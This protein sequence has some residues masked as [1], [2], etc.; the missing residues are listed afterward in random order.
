MGTLFY[1][2]WELTLFSIL[3]L[4]LSGYV[5]SRI[6]KSLKYAARKGRRNWVDWFLDLEET[7]A[8]MAVVKAFHAE[9]RFHRRFDA[10]NQRF[11]IDA[12]AVQARVPLISGF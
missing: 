7:L 8:G 5:I 9:D 4:P 3:F 6:A 11:Q 1:L 2:S 12:P 10:S